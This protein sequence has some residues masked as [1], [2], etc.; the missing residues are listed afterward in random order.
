[1]SQFWANVYLDALDHF[2]KHR[3]KARWYV[4]YCDDMVLLSAEREELAGWLTEIED[5]LRHQLRLELNERTKLRPVSDGI[6]FLGYIVR[7]DYLLVRRRVVG[8]LRGRLERAEARLLRAGMRV[9]GDGRSVFP[10]PWPVLSRGA[11]VAQFLPRLPAQ[12]FDP[13]AGSC[14]SGS[15]TPGWRSTSTGT[16]GRSTSAARCRASRCASRTR[17]PASASSF[18]ATC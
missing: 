2:V 11:A 6:D 15:D 14:G 13:S 8:N 4:R 7:P 12:S 17:S 9:A 5:F 16:D 1:M 3:L 18:P 10:W